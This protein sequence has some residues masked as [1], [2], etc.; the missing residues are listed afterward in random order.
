MPSR[1]PVRLRSELAGPVAVLDPV[2]VRHQA[3]LFSR[4][5]ISSSRWSAMRLT[6]RRTSI[7]PFEPPPYAGTERLNWLLKTTGG[8]LLGLRHRVIGHHR[9]DV[10]EPSPALLGKTHR[11]GS[12]SRLGP[13]HRVTVRSP[14]TGRHVQGLRLVRLR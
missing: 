4:R 13:V 2:A 8:R 12:P 10:P 14:P 7:P 6:V 9:L 3:V 5:F 1:P 11:F